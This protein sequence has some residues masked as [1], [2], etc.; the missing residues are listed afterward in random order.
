MI[1]LFKQC[2]QI[3]SWFVVVTPWEQALRVRGGRHVRFLDAGIYLKIP[4]FDRVFKQ[5]IRRRLHNI[6]TQTL[7]TNDNRVITYS[8]ALGYSV[9]DLKKLYDNLESATDTIETEAS[10]KVAHYISTHKFEECTPSAIEEYVLKNIDLQKYGLAGQEFYTTSCA[11]ARTYRLITGDIPCWN[12][13][14]PLCMADDT[15]HS[16]P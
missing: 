14:N 3:L 1:E 10:A 2:L 9:A 8:G 7:T 16:Q 6:R 4:L 13:D 11:T 5:S 12:H 15:K